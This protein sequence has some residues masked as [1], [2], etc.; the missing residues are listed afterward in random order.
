MD[1]RKTVKMMIPTFLNKIN[2]SLFSKVSLKCV[3]EVKPIESF[4]TISIKDKLVFL[5]KGLRF[6]EDLSN[7][8]I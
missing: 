5:N 7:D 8:N 3:L 4:L 2:T 6:G 1:V